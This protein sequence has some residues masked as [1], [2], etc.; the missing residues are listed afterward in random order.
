MQF[1]G[2]VKLEYNSLASVKMLDEEMYEKCFI[3]ILY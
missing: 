1:Y 3:I 2:V